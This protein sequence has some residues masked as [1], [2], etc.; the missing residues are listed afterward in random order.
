MN[1]AALW[2][3]RAPGRAR[4][5]AIRVALGAVQDVTLGY[6]ATLGI[7]LSAGRLF[8][9]RDGL[10]APRVAIVNES[11]ARLLFGSPAVFRKER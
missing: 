4:E 11:A 6:F 7:P 1:I 2:L 9:V 3:G 5:A 8:D 10:D